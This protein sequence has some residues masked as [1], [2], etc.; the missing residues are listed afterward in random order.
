MLPPAI[1]TGPRWPAAYLLVSMFFSTAAVLKTVVFASSNLA[2]VNS[3]GAWAKGKASCCL[4]MPNG[5]LSG[6]LFCPVCIARQA[7]DHSSAL[8]QDTVVAIKQGGDNL[9]ISNMDE[10][11]YPTATFSIDPK[12]ACTAA[13]PISVSVPKNCWC[14][15][16]CLRA[17]SYFNSFDTLQRVDLEHHTWANYFLAA[18]KVC[19]FIHSALLNSNMYRFIAM[20]YRD[21]SVLQWKRKLR[22]AWEQ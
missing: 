18:Y 6:V 8:P 1:C 9:T 11:Q 19:L 16:S 21:M 12:Q 4:A 14:S 10:T 22:N 3:V 5:F 17:Y 20:S 15:G 13:L 2:N 7:C